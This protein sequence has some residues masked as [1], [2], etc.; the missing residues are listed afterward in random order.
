MLIDPILIQQLKRDEGLRLVMY[1]DSVGVP[2]VGYGHNLKTPITE[3]AAHVILEDDVQ[4]VFDR[5]DVHL[6]WVALLDPVRQRVV[7][8]MAFNLGIAGLLKFRK[9][10]EALKVGDYRRAQLE[11]R[12]SEWSD[13][14]GDR[15]ERLMKMMLEGK[16]Y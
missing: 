3:T 14:V 11:M 9:M 5:L 10:L 6:P 1:L 16:D 4:K 7:E 13:Q 15:A 2:T 12:E 8:N